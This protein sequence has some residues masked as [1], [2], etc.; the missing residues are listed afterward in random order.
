M[1]ARLSALER[2]RIEATGS[3]GATA[4]DIAMVLGRHPATV[5]RELGPLRRPQD[6][7]RR[8]RGAG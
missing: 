7:V 4:V 5:C 1:A 2:A 8:G 6:C 3:A